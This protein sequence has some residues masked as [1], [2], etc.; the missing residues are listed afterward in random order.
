MMEARKLGLWRLLT[1]VKRDFKVTEA[2]KTVLLGC[3]GY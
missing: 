1:Y 2:L 3:Y